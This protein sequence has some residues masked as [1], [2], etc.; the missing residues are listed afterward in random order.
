[1]PADPVASP[2]EVSNL[3]RQIDKLETELR[4][5]REDALRRSAPLPHGAF[6][7]TIWRSPD[8]PCGLFPRIRLAGCSAANA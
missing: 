2:S 5:E 7:R 6:L 8:N 4:T 1:M 3:Q